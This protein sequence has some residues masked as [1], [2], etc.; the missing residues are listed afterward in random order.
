MNIEHIYRSYKSYFFVFGIPKP[1][2]TICK[3]DMFYIH[4]KFGRN[5]MKISEVE[6]YWC[7]FSFFIPC[8]APPY[9]LI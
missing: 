8:G 6:A 2:I 9:Q 3:N 4:G 1:K 7:F 5:R